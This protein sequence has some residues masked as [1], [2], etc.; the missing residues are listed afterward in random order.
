MDSSPFSPYGELAHRLLSP[1]QLTGDG[2]HDVSHLERVWR[3]AKA[4]HAEEGGD[5]ELLAA[6]VLLHDCVQ[7][8]K[9]SPLRDT[10]SRLAADEARK[11]LRTLGWGKPRIETAAGAIESHSY[12][13]GIA[14]ASLEGRILQDA[15]RLDAIGMTGIARCFYTAGH[16]GSSLYD[17]TDPRG[18]ARPLDDRRFALDHF[19][20]KLL[21]LV[22]GFQ[23]AAG[24]RLAQ[25]RQRALREFYEGM[26]AEIGS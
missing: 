26:L 14:P 22:D 2:A 4:I 20:R 5:L 18:E 25:R 8:S 3:N 11:I 10:A 6:A 21:K 16:M 13:A 19:P 9:D 23:T 17:P 7:I 15:D 12:S 1:F 24:Q